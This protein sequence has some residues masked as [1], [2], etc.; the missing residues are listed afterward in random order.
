MR[1]AGVRRSVAE[2]SA[3]LSAIANLL[4]VRLQELH[5]LARLDG[6]PDPVAFPG[7]IPVYLVAEWRDFLASGSYK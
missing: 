6:A 2:Q 3:P 5:R 4:G 7:C 1:C